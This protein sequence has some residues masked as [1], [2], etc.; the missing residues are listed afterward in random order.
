MADA[1]LVPVY[2]GNDVTIKINGITVALVQTITV[3][4][5][6]NRRQVYQAS[7]PLFAD[8]PVTTVGATMAATNMVPQT[9]SLATLGLTPQGSLVD[10]VGQVPYDA[11]VVDQNGKAVCTVHNSYFNQDSLDITANEP[12]SLNASWI[13]QDVTAFI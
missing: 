1:T 11:T 13:A 5:M 8:A 4:R 2:T 9:G 7:T 3:S 10:A 6:V 12:L